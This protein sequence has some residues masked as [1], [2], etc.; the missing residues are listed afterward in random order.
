MSAHSEKRKPQAKIFPLQA[1]CFARNGGDLSFSSRSLPFLRASE[2]RPEIHGQ[3]PPARRP[4][5]RT[6][7]V[8]LEHESTGV[9]SNPGA[10]AAQQR[11]I[12]GT[13]GRRTLE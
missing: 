9:E 6:N 13:A 3:C 10:D 1:E 4:I 5:E 8:E 12:H 11:G 7:R 2:S